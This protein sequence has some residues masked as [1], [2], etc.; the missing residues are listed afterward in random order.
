MDHLTDAPIANILILAGV[1]FL[2]V[3]LFGHI[4]GF[5]GSIF[6]NIEAGKSSRILAA[7]FGTALILGGAWMHQQSDKPASHAAAPTE[8]AINPSTKTSPATDANTDSKTTPLLTHADANPKQAKL[9]ANAYIPKKPQPYAAP[10]I[11]SADREKVPASPVGVGDDRLIGTWTNVIPMFGGIHTIEVMRDGQ[12][13]AAHIW[14]KCSS[15]ECDLGVHHLAVSGNTSTYEYVKGNLRHVG[16]MK[17]YAPNVLLVSIDIYEPGVS[18]QRHHNRVFANS[19]LRG[20][21][22]VAFSN[23]LDSPGQKAFAMTPAGRCAWQLKSST[24]DEATQRAL[25]YCQNHGWLD[26]R[27]ILLNDEG[28]Q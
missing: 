4:G 6:G 11:P 10:T 19:N 22:Q 27:I 26:C 7:V 17:V 18:K 2:A 20:P 3:G 16:S 15:G 5:I 21:V 14:D 12:G 9:T 25:Q 28:P 23:Y 8:P 13:L 1:I 24:A